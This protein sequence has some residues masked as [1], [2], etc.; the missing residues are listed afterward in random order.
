MSSRYN[1][2]WNPS[3]TEDEK[4]QYFFHVFRDPE[5]PE[6]LLTQLQAV[7]GEG[8]DAGS[9]SGKDAGTTERHGDSK[10]RKS[11]EPEPNGDKNQDDQAEDDDEDED[12]RDALINTTR[13]K[14]KTPCRGLLYNPDGSHQGD[15]LVAAA[16]LADR[17]GQIVRRADTS[18]IPVLSRAGV[19]FQAAAADLA[20]LVKTLRAATG[21][22]LYAFYHR[23]IKASR[24]LEE[25]LKESSSVSWRP[26]R[27]SKYADELRVL[28]DQLSELRN[29][30]LS[31]RNSEGLDIKPMRPTPT[32]TPTPSSSS[33]H[34]TRSKVP[35]LPSSQTVDLGSKNFTSTEK[36]STEKN[37]AEKNSTEKNSSEKNSS[38]KN[39]IEKSSTEK[40]T[41]E[42]SSTEKNS[43]RFGPRPTKNSGLTAVPNSSHSQQSATKP[44]TTN[45]PPILVSDRSSS[46]DTTAADIFPVNGHLPASPMIHP[47]HY[48]LIESRNAEDRGIQTIV[49]DVNR[50]Q[51]KLFGE[52]REMST[53]THDDIS[54][55]SKQLKANTTTAQATESK[56]TDLTH[57]MERDRGRYFQEITSLRSELHQA[58][59]TIM[60]NITHLLSYTQETHDTSQSVKKKL[61][62]IEEQSTKQ[63]NALSRQ[64]EMLRQQEELAIKHGNV[65]D[66]QSEMLWQLDGQARDQ[67]EILKQQCETQSDLLSQQNQRLAIQGDLLKQQSEQLAT[68]S[69]RLI[70]QGDLLKQQN[71][72][73]AMQGKQLVEQGE[74]VNK[75]KRELDE[76]TET[77]KKISR[78]TYRPPAPLHNPISLS[79]PTTTYHNPPSTPY[80]SQGYYSGTGGPSNGSPSS[81]QYRTGG[82]TSFGE[83]SSRGS[84]NGR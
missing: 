14:R 36:N 19:E 83:P 13:S 4:L 32:P 52:L 6:K 28:H 16:F 47:L 11:S 43:D 22:L 15:I 80:T 31:E 37:S 53:K 64:S 70:K 56:L 61:V 1:S 66:R 12:E 75:M 3:M 62:V 67:C 30:K 26:T 79:S 38:E 23:L 84:S 50:N 65:L 20:G 59:G 73:L 44:R 81:S 21:H 69:E 78:N 34:H 33:G 77:V 58:V 82:P 40:S 74:M 54:S 27:I 63:G 57:A 48:T 39:S 46:V 25:F 41:T 76:V 71:E 55:F 24:D 49:K 9:S 42:K 18:N 45:S 68:Q 2:H 5:D 60:N 35:I 29:K 8:T 51:D 7:E 10:Q 72:R 17:I